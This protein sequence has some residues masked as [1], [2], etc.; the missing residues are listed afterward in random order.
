MWQKMEAK[1]TSKDKIY[2]YSSFK[3]FCLPVLELPVL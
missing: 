1:Q 3:Q 2:V